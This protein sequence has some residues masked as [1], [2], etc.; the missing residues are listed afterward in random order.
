MNKNM[1]AGSERGPNKKAKPQGGNNEYR[2]SIK[3]L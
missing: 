2:R 1:E 3:Y